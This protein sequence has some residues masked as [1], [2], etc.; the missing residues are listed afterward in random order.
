M[1]LQLVSASIC[2][3]ETKIWEEALKQ[4]EAL[5]GSNIKTQILGLLKQGDPVSLEIQTI[6]TCL[7]T[8]CFWITKRKR[9]HLLSIAI[10]YLEKKL[11]KEIV[12]EDFRYG[13]PKNQLTLPTKGS[14]VTK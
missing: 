6:Y 5:R 1:N 3:W 7:K 12:K 11:F 9:N 13:K 8:L 14:L 10:L 2:M 4:I